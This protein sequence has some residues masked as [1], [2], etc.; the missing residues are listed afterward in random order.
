MSA[1]TMGT[2]MFT[3]LVV[4]STLT[5]SRPWTSQSTRLGAHEPEARE[6]GR[7]LAE[8]RQPEME[9][10]VDPLGAAEC[11][12]REVDVDD[13]RTA[14]ERRGRQR[15]PAPRPGRLRGCEERVE[16]AAG[17]GSFSPR[18]QVN[19][20]SSVSHVGS[21]DASTAAASRSSSSVS[22]H[23]RARSSDDPIARLADTGVGS[24]RFIPA[25]TQ[26]ASN[27]R[28]ASAGSCGAA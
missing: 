20:P 5:P 4:R 8:R 9:I 19:S 11:H 7:I 28:R 17:K 23:S 13:L 16:L 15:R 26:P 24:G 27:S 22:P 3:P 1:A 14:L 21:Y 18:P 25:E 12:R 10:A 2:R 6:G